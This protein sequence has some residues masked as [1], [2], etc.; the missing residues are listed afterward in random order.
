MTG[1]V[2]FFFIVFFIGVFALPSLVVSVAVFELVVRTKEYPCC[3]EPE[4]RVNQSKQFPL[5]GLYPFQL[6]GCSI[7]VANDANEEDTNLQTIEATFYRTQCW[8]A[9]LLVNSI[10][11][12]TK[13]RGS[14][15][16]CKLDAK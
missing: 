1:I 12:P 3:G 14:Q 9:M 10:L 2:L 6:A 4:S 8:C 7:P 5:M 11:K 13:G 15:K 16:S